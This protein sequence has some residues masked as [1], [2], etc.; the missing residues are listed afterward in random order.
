MIPTI[1][2]TTDMYRGRPKRI[3]AGKTCR[4]V[5]FLFIA[6]L[7]VSCA[8]LDPGK[9][10]M[11]FV[12]S[13]PE[14]KITS[15]TEA[16]MELGLMSK[17]Y[18]TQILKIQSIPIY[19]N[20]GSSDSTGGE[21]PKDISEMVKSTLNSIGGNLIYIPYDPSFVQN[22]MVTGYSNFQNKFIPDVVISGG[23]TEFDRGLETREKGTDLS[24]RFTNE[25]LPDYLPYLDEDVPYPT[26]EI[27][28]RYSNAGKA[29]LARITLDFN[30]L[31]FQT[32]AG[33]PRMNTVNSMEVQKVAGKK[34]LGISIFAQAFGRQGKIKKVQ[35]R[36]A[37]I[38]LLVELSMIQI[39][40]KQLILPYWKLLGD[41]ALPDRVVM[42]TASAFY[43]SLNQNQKIAF[44]QQQLF[45]H[46]YNIPIS[47]VFDENT[48]AALENFFQ[49]DTAPDIFDPENFLK[50][51]STIPVTKN[52]LKRRQLMEAAMQ[53]DPENQAPPEP[54]QKPPSHS[55]R[56]PGKSEQGKV[57]SK[58]KV[59]M[60]AEPEAAAQDAVDQLLRMLE[61]K[62]RKRQ[63]LANK[64]EID[65]MLKILEKKKTGG[66][67]D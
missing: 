51:W 66:R 26:K 22:Q 64:K 31:N 60:Q 36:H 52:T 9:V 49:T 18:A 57:E 39:I 14:P 27:D 47:G 48:T 21:I 3:I 1:R 34:E 23:I 46:G 59:E 19:D 58:S 41:D 55:R 61:V 42:E 56:S 62:K 6:F 33:I 25:G 13:R 40:G 67:G 35:G 8:S 24:S 54:Q 43:L 20:T 45:L 28:A 7:L 10:N 32:M 38:R 37:A 11:E 16:L 50:I 29:G 12:R 53:P 30:M 65:Q 63:E 2:R 44:T 15:Y 17:I 5:G 4:A